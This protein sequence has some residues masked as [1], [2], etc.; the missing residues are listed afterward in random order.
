MYRHLLN[1][2]DE[3]AMSGTPNTGT[4][5]Q[6]FDGEDSSCV[7]LAAGEKHQRAR[8][9]STQ[10]YIARATILFISMLLA[11][12]EGEAV[13]IARAI[14]RS[15]RSPSAKG[16]LRI[17]TGRREVVV[18]EILRIPA[19]D[20]TSGRCAAQREDSQVRSHICVT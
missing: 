10:F 4:N 6:S 7:P 3:V 15:Q 2:E 11:D 16:K 9:T 18:R 13:A 12:V 19:A 14:S 20:A 5:D 17:F 1:V 8:I